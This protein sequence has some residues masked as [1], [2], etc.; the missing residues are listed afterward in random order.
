MRH[1]FFPAG[2]AMSLLFSSL[3]TQANTL[4]E[5]VANAIDT[6]PDVLQQYARYQSSNSLQ[7]SARSDYYPQVK[8][9]AGYGR[10]DTRYNSGQKID[11]QLDRNE[12]GISISQM[13][14]NGFKTQADVERLGQEALSE[15]YALVSQA[16]NTALDVCRVYLDTLKAEQVF[17]LAKRNV[18]DHMSAQSDIKERVG[19]GLSSQSDLSQV[20]ARLAS[21]RASLMAA[22]NN[23]LD[24][25]AEYYSVVG[26]FPGEL[27]DPV[28]D[29]RLIPDSLNAALTQAKEQHPE[30]MVAK[31]DIA[32]AKEEQRAAKHGFYPRVSVEVAANQN[33]DIGG[34]EGPDED[35][36]LMLKLEYDLFNGG[37]DKHRAKASGWRY[38]EA[39]AIAKRT[40]RE[41]DEGTRLAWNARRFLSEQ[42]RLY[43]ENVDATSEAH[44][45]Y[46]QQFKLG[47]RSLLDVLDS[48]VELFLARRNYIEAKYD[49]KLAI[50]RVNN[51]I[52]T[53]LYTLRVDYP[54]QWNNSD[55]EG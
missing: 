12:M 35:A 22:N 7:D 50:Y 9:T 15:R 20:N 36:R 17:Q 51:A 29:A 13:L 8:L 48:Q 6:N 30:L 53:L 21:A 34:F 42:T 40:R 31:A 5:A 41:V 47:R 55:E 18:Q 52:G 23:L 44:A 14:F 3:Q 37:R 38:N 4:E 54:S 26:E 19:K 16:E 11:S 45:G 2:I 46:I 33:E 25:R 10:E 49:Q 24:L 28:S 39:L 27:I 32:A 1:F 43:Q